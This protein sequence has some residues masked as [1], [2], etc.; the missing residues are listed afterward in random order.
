M[1]K[2]KN[3]NNIH[4]KRNHK[5]NYLEEINECQNHIFN[6]YHYL[7]GDI[8]PFI[9]H[10]GRP[11]LLGL[12]M[13]LSSIV[14]GGV[15]TYI[16]FLHGNFDS[17]IQLTGMIVASILIYGIIGLQFI[18]GIRLIKKSYKLK[19]QN[20]SKIIKFCICVIFI[21]VLLLTVLHV[22]LYKEREIKIT[23]PDQYYWKSID[24]TNYIHL[25]EKDI[26]LKYSHNYDS[27]FKKIKFHDDEILKNNSFI[28]VYKQN[29]LISSCGK[30]IKFTIIRN[31]NKKLETLGTE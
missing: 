27:Q 25:V 11:A 14:Y 18:G 22:S 10:P 31:Q 29:R 13:I 8:P 23:S 26:D 2:I 4:K 19:P 16:F 7:G 20:K 12:F 3:K 1:N 17:L 5:S 30:L 21:M 6:P 24:N 28:I 9:K 15:Y